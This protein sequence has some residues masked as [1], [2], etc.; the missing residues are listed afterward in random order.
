MKKINNHKQ[1]QQKKKQLLK[2][3]K[4]LE[5]VIHANWIE[6][7]HSLKPHS[8]AGEI[9]SKAFTAHSEEENSTLADILG[10]AAATLTKVAVEKIEVKLHNW[11]QKR[12]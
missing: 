4:E 6:L 9:F 2:R 12:S 1:L 11:L 5:S 8:V 10:K 3:H 7:K